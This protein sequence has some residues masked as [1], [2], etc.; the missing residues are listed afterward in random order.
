LE[1]QVRIVLVEDHPIVRLGLKTV[2]DAQPDMAV[3][4]E[5]Q[6]PAEAVEITA[7]LRPDLAI[8]ALR[9]QGELC[10][11]EVCREIK[12]LPDTPAVLI[13]SAFNSN[14]A[15]ASCF[16][17]DADGFVYKGAESGRLLSSIR[18][19]YAGR[20]AWVSGVESK[21]HSAQLRRAVEESGLTPKEREVLGF[22]LQRF[23]NS[24][25]AGELY[26]ELPTV[27]THVSS[28]LR[29][30]GLSSRQELFT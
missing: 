18:D 11:V 6:T 10:G 22:M 26:I 9:L 30:L 27:K 12:N 20:R 8:L 14:E 4:G 15:I 7:S 3:V 25:I 17:S 23:T 29:K 19:T 13:Y 16:L 21:E 5:A 2:L 1:A 24:Q 28:I